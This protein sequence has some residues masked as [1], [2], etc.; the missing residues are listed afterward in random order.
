MSE[1]E[2][3]EPCPFCGAAASEFMWRG[4]V[5]CADEKCGAH[6]AN[7][8]VAQWN[9]RALPS[10]SDVLEE[11]ARVAD[12]AYVE[13]GHHPVLRTGA[14]TIAAAIRALKDTDNG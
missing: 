5:G 13:R 2:K 4:H 11:A 14:L 8:P 10:R 7:L 12:A 3:L 1:T 6:A 9:R